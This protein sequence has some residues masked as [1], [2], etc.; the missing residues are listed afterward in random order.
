MTKLSELL[1]PA[2]NSNT[3]LESPSKFAKETYRHKGHDRHPSLTSPLEALA[4]VATNSSSLRSPTKPSGQ[5]P[6]SSTG[7]QYLL[8]SS[9]PVQTASNHTSPQFANNLSGQELSYPQAA[10][11]SSHAFH[12]G[13]ER[14][15][16]A[17]RENNELPKLVPEQSSTT[18]TPDLFN[19]IEPREHKV[20]D[21]FWQSLSGERS[22]KSPKIE[23]NSPKRLITKFE[24]P[25]MISLPPVSG[26][27]SFNSA[28]N[29]PAGE[30]IAEQQDIKSE[31]GNI[32]GPTELTSSTLIPTTPLAKT[33]L[34]SMQGGAS[35][36]ASGPSAESGDIFNRARETANV[37]LARSDVRELQPQKKRP[38]PKNGQRA[39]KR[40]IASVVKKPSV[41][42]RKTR[43]DSVD[44]TPRRS[45]TPASSHASRT[46]AP[47]N[48]KQNSLTPFQ[49]SPAPA[50]KEEEILDDEEVDDDPDLF[51]ICRKPDDHKWMI[52]CDGGCEDWFH[53]RCVEMNERDGNLIDKYIC[54]QRGFWL[55]DHC[56]KSHPTGPNC[57]KRGIGPTTWKAMCRLAS[58][59]NPA[60]VTGLPPSKY[61]SDEH[62]EEFMASR[63]MA[64][65]TNRSSAEDGYTAARKRRRDNYTN[66][67]GNGDTSPT[68]GA[69]IEEDGNSLHLRGGLLRTSELKT[70]ASGVNGL[71]E[72]KGLGD[73]V[74]SS[75]HV[76]LPDHNDLKVE[77]GDQIPSENNDVTYTSEEKISL[78]DIDAKR[79]SLRHR[80]EA[81]EAR[82][83]FLGLVKA[84]AKSMLEERKK[85]DNNKDSICGYDTR[86][87]WSDDEFD[88]WR[89]SSEG[90]QAME[91]GTLGLAST[92][93]DADGDEAMNDAP[94]EAVGQGVCQK[95]RCAR[96]QNWYR[97]Q[98]QGIAAEK[99]ECRQ[100]MRKLEFEE[101]G[102]GE[103]AMLRYLEREDETEA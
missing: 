5:S 70:L 99:D 67:S 34:T 69:T 45:G 97:T 31:L 35:A 53:G 18:Q 16:P 22:E 92:S 20:V 19:K 73:G 88:A 74:L 29:L 36:T 17:T 32:I 63:A 50:A 93:T 98:Q 64:K 100:E 46:P 62:G 68:K 77:D 79:V 9:S 14:K 8:P 42:R 13:G 95:K 33:R 61:C 71:D 54:K 81:L 6:S 41:K 4:I 96:H 7:L 80:R 3:V 25:N 47:R 89:S 58:C 90:Q 87:S 21:N 56:T 94:E 102:V 82:E 85:N 24:D 86:L 37:S 76:T 2:P 91:N 83:R 55:S 49:S 65:D 44:S 30:L 57:E 84:R 39:E 1:N 15:S 59:R 51:C 26:S 48:R 28:S 38:V 75:P 66:H 103:R 101:K 27:T 78:L 11:A 40:G 72:F 43:D 52:A 12:P 23:A 10:D 60:R